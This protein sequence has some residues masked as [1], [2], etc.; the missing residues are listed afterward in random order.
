MQQECGGTVQVCID[1]VRKSK[2]HLVLKLVMDMKGT[3]AAFYMHI[4]SKKK[5]SAE[6]GR[7]SGDKR[8][9]TGQ[10]IQCLLSLHLYQ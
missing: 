10:G 1:G 6:W 8:Y 4:R 3:K 9:G 2:A 7:A 5:T